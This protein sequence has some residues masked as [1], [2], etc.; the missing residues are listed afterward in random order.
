MFE[1]VQARKLHARYYAQLIESCG[2]T[3]RDVADLR[4]AIDKSLVT[5]IVFRLDD[6]LSLAGAA[7]VVGDGIY[8]AILYDLLVH[9]ACRKQGIGTALIDACQLW[10]AANTTAPRLEAIS[11]PSEEAQAFYRSLGWSSCLAFWKG[12]DA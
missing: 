6:R 2:W 4:R 1:I 8:N 7:R 3:S 5:F 12:S 11:A 9:P 10:V